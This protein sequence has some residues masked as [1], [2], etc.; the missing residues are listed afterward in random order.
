VVTDWA[1]FLSL[2][3]IKSTDPESEDPAVSSAVPEY[4]I[5]RVVDADRATTGIA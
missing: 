3:R 4:G 5:T 2:S 1:P